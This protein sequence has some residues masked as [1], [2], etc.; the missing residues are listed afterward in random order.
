MVKFQSSFSVTFVNW[1]VNKLIKSQSG[2][3]QF[4]FIITSSNRFSS[5]LFSHANTSTKN[6]K[7]SLRVKALRAVISRRIR[8]FETHS[9]F[10]KV[11]RNRSPRKVEKNFWAL[12]SRDMK[13]N[14]TFCLQQLSA[15]E[16]SAKSKK[17]LPS[18]DIQWIFMYRNF[19][20]IFIMKDT[21]R[22]TAL[23]IHVWSRV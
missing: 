11:A 6:D 5:E 7:L 12:K 10:L 13:I 2:L 22:R 15:S 1:S 19:F 9:R 21:R 17:P 14:K 8:P 16:S 4:A 3:C 18:L 23:S 20:L